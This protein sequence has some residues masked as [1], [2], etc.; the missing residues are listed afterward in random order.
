FSLKATDKKGARNSFTCVA[1][2]PKDDCIATGHEDGKIRLWRN[3][4]Q[5]KEYTYSTQHWHHDAVNTLCF[6]P[7]GMHLLSGGVES[8]LV[9]W[10]CSEVNK[11]D[12][13]PRLG[14]AI[15]HISVSADGQTYTTSH[16]DNSTRPRTH[17][18]KLDMKKRIKQSTYENRRN[19]VKKKKKYYF[20]GQ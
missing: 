16:S 19:P 17:L 12:F 9:Q 13:L 10:H 11:K 6:T 20:W 8:V 15:F 14:G 2:H 4:N 1:C 3:F 7:E 5:K 18:E